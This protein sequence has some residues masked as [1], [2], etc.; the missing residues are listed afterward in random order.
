MVQKVFFLTYEKKMLVGV[1]YLIVKLLKLDFF[2]CLD[3]IF[4]LK[5]LS[6]VAH[7]NFWSILCLSM[8]YFPG[9]IIC[10][11]SVNDLD[12]LLEIVQI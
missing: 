10:A 7:V 5:I 11:T 6:F 1:N 12:I 4:V 2:R 3:S 8:L 9:K